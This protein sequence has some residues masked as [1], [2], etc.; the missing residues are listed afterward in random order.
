MR[1]TVLSGGTG[2]PKL[3]RGLRELEADFSV[4]VNTGEDDEILGL[5]VSP[6]VDTVLYTLAGIVND[7]TWY[8]IKDDGFRGH[9]FLERLGVDEPLRIGDADRALKQY[10]TYLM[11]EKGLKLSE[12]VDEIRRRL[13]IKWKVYPMTDDRVTTIVETDEGDLHFRE[14]WVERGGKPPVR[15]VRYEGAEEASPPPD[16]VDELLRADVVLIGP[17]N[18]VTSI[19][20][21][22]S[23]SEIRHIVREKPVVM[24]S[25]FIGREPVSGPAGKLMRAVGFEPSVRGLVEYYREWGVEPDV[26]IMDERDDVELPE[27]LE[28]VRTDTLM[29]DEKDSVRL[30][31]EVLR[32]V[33]EL[34]G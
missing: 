2:T 1:L 8:G 20:P 33:E 29:R 4:I 10:R 16:A 32:I 9:E 17:S 24:V 7:E 30:A 34:V 19:G 13:G 22:L 27:G 6:D 28:V 25:P 12:A 5:Y 26:L 11:R 21:I 18:P 23:I 14:F 31:R 15:G 3:L